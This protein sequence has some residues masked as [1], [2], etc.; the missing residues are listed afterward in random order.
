MLVPADIEG[1]HRCN[2]F[3]LDKVVDAIGIES[4]V[5]D[6]CA[7]G[8][9]QVVGGAGFQK[10]ILTGGAYDEVGDLA[11]G[12]ADVRRQVCSGVITRCWKQR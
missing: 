3:R 6:D 12:E 4:T 2:G 5:V 8:D 11:W 7:H 9:R 1:N 10:A